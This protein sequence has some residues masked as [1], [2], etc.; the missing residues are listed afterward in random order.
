[1][2]K[3]LYELSVQQKAQ[4]N[5]DGKSYSSVQENINTLLIDMRLYEK[6]LKVNNNLIDIYIKLNNCMNN[7][8]NS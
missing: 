3:D 4:D 5:A 1:M 6:G 2:A 8:I 7:L